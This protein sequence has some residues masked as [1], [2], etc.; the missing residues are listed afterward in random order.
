M[1]HEHSAFLQLPVGTLIGGQYAITGVLG[2]GGFATV[3]R[4]EQR[5]LDRPVAI[6][7]LDPVLDEGKRQ[8]FLKR[9]EREARIAANVS[10]PNVVTIYAHGLHEATQQAWMVM[11]L[12][13]GHDLDQELKSAG[14]MDP[15]RAL[16]LLLPCLDALG[17]VHAQGVIHKDLK[18]SNLFV[19]HPRRSYKEMLRLLD[20]G[21]ARIA[22]GDITQLTAVGRFMGTP[23][24]LAPEYIRS[25][26]ITAAVDVYQMGLILVE[27]LTGEPVVDVELPMQA[28]HIH[29]QGLL[30]IPTWL[31][32]G[33]LGPVLARALH[34]DPNQRYPNAHTLCAALQTIDPTQIHTE[35]APSEHHPSATSSSS[36]LH[37]PDAP[38]AP[39]AP[40]TLERA[41]QPSSGEL[42]IDP[43]AIEHLSPTD[44]TQQLSLDQ[45]TRGAPVPAA[46]DTINQPRPEPSTSGPW[47]ALHR[48]ASPQESRS[49][50]HGAARRH[51]LPPAFREAAMRGAPAA[52]PP[53]SG[54]FPASTSS[55]GLPA[56]ASGFEAA[57][58]V[59]LSSVA[60]LA[61]NMASAPTPPRGT[62][63]PTD[64]AA[65]ATPPRGTLLP[66]TS[67]PH[68]P[69]LAPEP[70]QASAS[71]STLSLVLLG[72]TVLT[73]IAVVAAG[74]LFVTLPSEP[75]PEP[76]ERPAAQTPAPP[77][78]PP[79]ADE[80]FSAEALLAE[81]QEHAEREEWD[82]A[83]ERFELVLKHEPSNA[84][85]ERGRSQALREKPFK[86][87]YEEGKEALEAERYTEALTILRGIPTELSLYGRRVRDKGLLE[88]AREGV[89][90][91]IEE[92]LNEARALSKRDPEKALNLIEEALD[93]D[94]GHR[95]ALRLQA[96]IARRLRAPEKLTSRERYEKKTEALKE[97][98]QLFARS[99]YA[100]AIVSAK[101]ALRFG[102]GGSAHRLL[103][104][105]YEKQGN[106]GQAVHHYNILLKANCDSPLAKTIRAKVKA[107]GGQP[108]C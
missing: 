44:A 48:S 20:F 108:G 7:M 3:Y 66:H 14:P 69:A 31:S 58:T 6:K 49:G 42:R 36:Q 39:A 52:A 28:L 98:R 22:Q 13:D 51:D 50:E 81:A 70:A 32:Q 85:A 102:A 71:T 89:Q 95:E 38:S 2:R 40:D 54:N 46:A 21:V 4:G 65:A 80:G 72:G 82:A 96:H 59:D 77:T 27:M 94:P 100:Q 62:P 64:L 24:Y 23:K 97:A 105:S 55:P 5:G 17:D 43:S 47:G 53:S 8:R 11:E 84:V 37:L 83:A 18:P 57:N 93:L 15:A 9:L 41:L 75:P 104:I 25:E 10:H 107:L 73:V 68:L 88:R 90:S 92:Q 29:L 67:S 19:V 99:N 56:A 106:S 63:R 101:E 87:A 16:R 91:I 60:E 45:L 35:I 34:A 1:S 26:Q 30:N 33:P 12:L 61:V 86:A 79:V 78:P 103:A 76:P 74:V